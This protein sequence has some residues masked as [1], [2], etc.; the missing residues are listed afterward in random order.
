MK[1]KVKFEQSIKTKEGE[2]VLDA[3]KELKLD[4]PAP[5]KGKGKCGKCLVKIVQG[6]V[7]EPNDKERKAL[8]N[9]DLEKGL[10]L[11]CQVEI[12][13]DMTVKLP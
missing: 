7:E 12:T 2:T 11:A 13:D 3:A 5:C 1:Y 4:I 9:K 6:K 8:S 10:R